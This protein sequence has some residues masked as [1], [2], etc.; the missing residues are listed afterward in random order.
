MK[1]S[2]FWAS[3][4]TITIVCILLVARFRADYEVILGILIFSVVPS[5]PIYLLRKRNEREVSSI[6]E[7][8]RKRDPENV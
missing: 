7:R 3:T 6:L 5:I 8:N 4:I 1:S 2:T